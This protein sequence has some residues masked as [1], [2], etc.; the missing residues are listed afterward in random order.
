[1][2]REP[3]TVGEFLLGSQAP[4]E[5]KTQ[6]SARRQRDLER[7]DSVVALKKALEE[8]SARFPWSYAL[9]QIEAK[10]VDVLDVD[11]EDILGATWA[12]VAE[13][14]KYLDPDEVSL[15]RRLSLR[16]SLNTRSNP[17]FTLH[18]R[19]CSTRSGLGRFDST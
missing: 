5:A 8:R 7:S 17:L 11:V 6:T 9:E 1:M 19:C 18:L 13:L 2:N 16:T 4:S 3:F 15:L 10:I 14:A 12:K